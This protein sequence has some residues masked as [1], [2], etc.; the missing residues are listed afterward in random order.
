MSKFSPPPAFEGSTIMVTIRSNDLE[1]LK[2]AHQKLTKAIENPLIT[3][4]FD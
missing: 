3:T 1:S 4:L 2:H